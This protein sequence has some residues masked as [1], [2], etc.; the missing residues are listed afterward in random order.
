M[1]EHATNFRLL[2]LKVSGEYL[3]MAMYSSD[4]RAICEHSCSKNNFINKAS[5]MLGLANNDRVLKKNVSDDYW[6]HNN[7]VYRSSLFARS[8]ALETMRGFEQHLF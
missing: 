4:F 1:L 7:A 2:N 6:R 5:N 8:L 3:R